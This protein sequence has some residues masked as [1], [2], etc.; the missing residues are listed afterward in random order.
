MNTLNIIDEKEKDRSIE[1]KKYKDHSVVDLFSGCGGLAYGFIMEG[2]EISSGLEIDSNA[3]LTA[4]YN[5]HWKFGKKHSHL[6]EDINKVNGSQLSLD[7]RS[8]LITIGGPPC[9][10]YSMIGRAKLKSLGENRFGL[11]DERAFLYKEFVRVSLEL[12]SEAIVMENVPESVNFLGMNIPQMVSDT[13]EANGYNAVW[14]ILNAA[15]FGVPQTRRRVFVIAI[16]KKY[17]DIEFLPEPTHSNLYLQTEEQQL[18]RYQ[19]FTSYR[20][21]RLPIVGDLLF[22]PWITTGQALSDLP[23]LFPNAV[24]KYPQIKMETKLNYK[25]PPLNEFQKQMRDYDDGDYMLNVDA[26][27]FRRT[28]R[29]F[30]IFEKMKPNDNYLDAHRIALKLFEE[31]CFINGITKASHEKEYNALK[32]KYVPPYDT[33]KFHTKW[34][35]LDPQIPSHT[36]V[37]HLGTDTYSHINPFEPRGISVREAARLQSF[38]DNFI[39]NVPM[40]SAYTQ[41]GNA[42]PPLLAKA[43]AK[44]V[45]KNLFKV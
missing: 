41:I 16:K 15:D 4:S 36:L 6:N 20:N 34:R 32:K 9:Q 39:F 40:G 30:R 31:A 45:K 7:D 8:P 43:V 22:S 21:F 33:T 13:L 10:A 14:T 24:E 17:G 12:D 26:N 1:V 29:D 2:M 11:A 38:P 28:M 25:A 3:C 5:L 42:V 27:S 19:K 23:S 18:A 44:A 37:A 35:R